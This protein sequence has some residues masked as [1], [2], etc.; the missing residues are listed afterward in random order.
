MGPDEIITIILVLLCILTIGRRFLTRSGREGAARNRAA[1]ALQEAAKSYETTRLPERAQATAAAQGI[2]P[3]NEHEEM[4]PPEAIAALVG[5]GFSLAGSAVAGMFGRRVTVHEG[6]VTSMPLEGRA[7]VGSGWF[8]EHQRKPE[9][10]PESAARAIEPEEAPELI[11]AAPERRRD[12][13]GRYAEEERQRYLAERLRLPA[14]MPTAQLQLSSDPVA[15][16]VAALEVMPEYAPAPP[17]KLDR[18]S[19]P[20]FYNYHTGD[21]ELY[22][23]GK[24]GEGFLGIFGATGGGKGNLLRYLALNVAAAGP[25]KALLV[26]FDS[27]AGVDYWF[28]DKIPAEC[29]YST[30]PGDK[31]D[32]KRDLTA[33]LDFYAGVMH[34]RYKTFRATEV[35]NVWEY[36]AAVRAG[37][38][39]G[40]ELPYIVCI[41]D[42]VGDYPKAAAGTVDTLIRMSRAAGF[43]MIVAT[44][45][46]TTDALS[47]QASNNLTNRMVFR[48]TSKRQ[49][50]IYLNKTADEGWLYEPSAINRS[51][52]VIWRRSGEE[53]RLGLVPYMAKDYGRALIEEAQEAAAQAIANRAERAQ[54]AREDTEA[55]QTTGA[56]E[57]PAQ[58]LTWDEALA[59]YPKLLTADKVREA[60]RLLAS[61]ELGVKALARKLY[62]GDSGDRF[63]AAKA[64]KARREAGDMLQSHPQRATAA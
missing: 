31:V 59:R 43:V 49:S 40:T 58:E 39:A 6:G 36:N 9:R 24:Q 38:V 61:E 54:E 45:Y 20:V 33:G 53:E 21:W 42:E 14:F 46:P 15:N 32:A 10:A 11:R 23:V 57:E 2:A 8:V 55:A 62:G 34:D 47:S 17:V 63:Y 64:L 56:A 22:H 48:T 52:V 35:E 25:G 13:H 3:E 5:Y 51:G 44:Q 12:D 26:V 50:Y 37:L 27:K 7:P 16:V 60:G 28:T 30:K 29:Y 18:L 41:C 4:S 19:I 1:A